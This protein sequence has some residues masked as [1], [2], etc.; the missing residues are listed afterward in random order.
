MLFL[1]PRYL[2]AIRRVGT[3]VYT[4]P[5]SSMVARLV[6]DG[7]RPS[8]HLVS[9]DD[10]R[11]LLRVNDAPQGRMAPVVWLGGISRKADTLI[12]YSPLDR[13]DA[14]SGWLG[15]ELHD[16]QDVLAPDFLPPGT[17][18]G[19]YDREGL[20]VV[21]R[22]GLSQAVSVDRF[23]ADYYGFAG[24]GWLP[25]YVLLS[26]SIGVGGL[27]VKYALP[28][29]RL[30]R[31]EA[32]VIGR[33]VG[34]VAVFALG[35]LLFSRQIRRRVL[36]PMR[37]QYRELSE[38][39]TLNQ[40]ILSMA[41]IGL[42]LVDN[43]R[44][45]VHLANAFAR[46]WLA[47]DAQWRDRIPG[48]GEADRRTEASL[49]DGRVLHVDAVVLEYRGRRAALC[50]IRD[51]SAR[52]RIED[53]LARARRLAEEANQAKTRFLAMLSHEIRTPLHG[54]TG[55]LELFE[56]SD[57]PPGKQP[58]FEALAHSVKTL[59][60]IVNDAL[61][62]SQIEAGRIHIESRAFSPAD[63]VDEV[64]AAYEA[65]ARVKGLHLYA[66]MNVEMERV[67]LGDSLRLRQILG[68]L[69]SNAIKFTASGH[70]IIRAQARPD[71]RGMALR[72]QVVDSG[73]GIDPDDLPYLFDPYFS[74]G[75]NEHGKAAGT[76]LGLTISRMLAELMG[77]GLQVA[78]EPGLGTSMALDVI[79]PLA[80]VAP[81]VPRRIP[82]LGPQRVCVAGAAPEIVGNVCQW[83][84]HWGAWAVP[85][86]DRPPKAGDLRVCLNQ[87]PG[88]ASGQMARVRIERVRTDAD[89]RAGDDTSV[90][91]VADP[92]TRAIGLAIEAL[93]GTPGLAAARAGAPSAGAPASTQSQGRKALLVDDHP[94]NLLVLGNQ[95]LRLGY[96][97]ARERSA[98]AA[99][100]RAD[101]DSFAAILTDVRMSGMDG[102]ALSRALRDR[103]Y[104]GVIFG[105]TA[106]PLARSQRQWAAAG[107]DD[108]L[109]KPFSFSVLEDRLD[110]HA[111]SG[112]M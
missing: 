71:D 67:L 27:R 46:S 112:D 52:K 30:L 105:V 24:E 48:P 8:W 108:L 74:P 66:L 54:I 11:G 58:Y 98:E 41:P 49:P 50:L 7:K 1:T 100:Q 64:V 3:L 40:T 59:L 99:L 21:E 32:S 110:A 20:V 5:F 42:A 77:G 70:V 104:D 78:S 91:W 2:D 10:A 106:D 65:A 68:N 102:Y 38:S 79:L 43:E 69:V 23:A 16:L 14:H 62:L 17:L 56:P 93:Q 6:V 34:L 88:T 37:R 15:L 13:R 19:L 4:Q 31:D 103:G 84:R 94:V 44:H 89:G 61:D 109:V 51:V 22:G 35:V 18:Y 9:G 87:Y 92:S 107:M 33:A 45:V 29:A 57:I 76:G 90:A 25:R 26:K 83:L 39:L 97:V 55:T 36:V 60:R 63:L 85:D 53:N 72:F 86:D 101:L 12:A 73:V 95:L 111:P 81:E 75:K 82:V 80:E 47:E 96:E 28:I